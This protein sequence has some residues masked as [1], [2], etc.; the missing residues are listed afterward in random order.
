MLFVD[1]GA[2]S[3]VFAAAVLWRHSLSPKYPIGSYIELLPSL[4]LIVAGFGIQG[5]YPGVMIHPAEELRRIVVTLTT[6]FLL[7]ASSAFLWRDLDLYSRSV[8]LV[9]WVVAGPLVLL[10]RHTAR[11]IFKRKRWWGVSAIIMGS[12]AAAERVS[13]TLQDGRWGIRVAGIVIDH[14]NSNWPSDL[15]PNLGS[16]DSVPAIALGACE[17]AIMAMPHK[18]SQ[19]IRA[20]IEARCGGCK[21]VL[22]IP[23]LPGL[24]SLGVVARQIGTEVGF[25][26]PQRLFHRGPAVIKRSLDLFLSLAAILSLTPL[27]I[28]LSLFVRLSSRGSIFYGQQRYG[29]NGRT[30]KALKFRTMVPNADHILA[31]HLSS[32]PEDLFEWQRDHKLK[33]DP[34]VTP[35]GK[36][37]RRL[38]LDEL[39]QLFNVFLGHMSLVGPRP[40]VGAEI[41]KYG[42]CFNLYSRVRPGITG[43]W[44]VSGRNNTTYEERVALDQYYVNNWSIW[45]DI[46]IL[47]RTLRTVISAEGAY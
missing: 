10:S 4:I 29:R 37:M 41:N 28:L 25:E 30:F 14:P 9:V 45:L 5:L 40:I 3:L 42:D 15:P 35:L 31:K 1:L 33:K 19:E 22:L 23:E 46:Y 32:H 47:A 17:Y 24:F 6:V 12:G 34:R 13:R 8:F 43:L 38:S 20:I 26:V 2:L 21:N 11:N 44:Q 39:P 36:W 7:A 27:L 16:L 18:S